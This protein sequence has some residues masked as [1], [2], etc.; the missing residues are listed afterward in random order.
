MSRS[1]HGFELGMT[2]L[3]LGFLLSLALLDTCPLQGIS[4]MMSYA[5]GLSPLA[6]AV[7]AT[8]YMNT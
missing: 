2:M 7:G 8:V 3:I 6:L 5:L 4:P 1:E